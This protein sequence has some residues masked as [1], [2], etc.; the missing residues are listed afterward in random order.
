MNIVELNINEGGSLRQHLFFGVMLGNIAFHDLKLRLCYCLNL[1]N[2]LDGNDMEL[3]TE[4]E[5]LSIYHAIFKGEVIIGAHN[6]EL[7]ANSLA[8]NLV[9]LDLFAFGITNAALDNFASSRAAQ[10]A[11]DINL[12]RD[13]LSYE[14]MEKEPLSQEGKAVLQRCIRNEC[15]MMIYPSGLEDMIV[16]S[17]LLN[18]L[19]LTCI[20]H[21]YNLDY[22]FSI[23]TRRFQSVFVDAIHLQAHSDLL[24]V[25]IPTID[26]E[27]NDGSKSICIS[28]PE[29]H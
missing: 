12:A 9:S 8:L 4:E 18:H 14:R 21:G 3:T 7:M 20:T 16:D 27:L 13:A 1:K 23:K 6:S 22:L 28:F 11:S 10:R 26:K 29:S 24:R 19:Y 25:H 5:L 2:E 17:E 15:A